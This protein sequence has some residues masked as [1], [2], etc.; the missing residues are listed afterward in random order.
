MKHFFKYTFVILITIIFIASCDIKPN[1]SPAK[2]LQQ[3]DYIHDF[4]YKTDGVYLSGL[5]YP[6]IK[7]NLIKEG[8]K[9]TNNSNK[10]MSIYTNGEIKLIDTQIESGDYKGWHMIAEAFPMNSNNCE[11]VK[12]SLPTYLTSAE[13]TTKVEYSNNYCVI[14]TS[15]HL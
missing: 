14:L 2:V 9:R 11:S 13:Y 8:F 3:L 7:N 1:M 6:A 12:H 4:I 15:A 10:H 5:E